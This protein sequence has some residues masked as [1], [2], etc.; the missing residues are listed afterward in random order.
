MDTKYEVTVCLLT[1]NNEQYINRAIDSLLRQSFSLPYQILIVND[2]SSDATDKIISSYLKENTN[3]K[4]KVVNNT[5]ESLSRRDCI[6]Y[7]DGKYIMWLDGDDFYHEKCI[8][9]MYEAISKNDADLVN[10]SLYYEKKKD[11]YTKELFRKK[12]TYNKLEA[13]NA[14]FSDITFRGFVYTKIYRSDILKNLDLNFPKR[15]FMYEDKII[16]FLYLLKSNKV[17]SIKNRNVYYNKTNENSITNTAK[18]RLQ[19]NINVNAYIRYLIE[20]ENDTALLKVFRRHYFRSKL[21][22]LVDI[23][24]SKFTN[25][26]EKKIVAKTAKRE[27]KEIYKSKSF[28]R[29]NHTYSKFIDELESKKE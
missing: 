24:F 7:A 3:I 2:S 25:R 26:K 9:S 8:E 19:D 21:L 12:A 16:N 18:N 13:I 14:L 27:L 22:L 5:S 20:K 6:A 28:A 15:T 29:E 17:V 11:K 23:S 4:Y 1:H 10:C